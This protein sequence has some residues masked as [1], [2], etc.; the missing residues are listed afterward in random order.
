[1]VLALQE[2]YRQWKDRDITIRCVRVCKFLIPNSSII[3]FFAID[4][5]Q[6]KNNSFIWSN[7]SLKIRVE[8]S[9]V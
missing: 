1:M 9:I 3:Q 2:E 6:N 5:S 8:G 7:C 4:L